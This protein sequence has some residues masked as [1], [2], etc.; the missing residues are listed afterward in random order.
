MKKNLLTLGALILSISASAQ[1]GNVLTYVGD[2]ALV[3]VMDGAL[4]Y[5]GGGW[6][7]SALG[8]VVNSGD[9]MVA[10][11]SA[12]MFKLDASQADAFVLK[13]TDS[14]TYGQLYISGIAQ[15]NIGGKVKKE[16]KADY[17]H[18]TD[19][20]SLGRQQ[21][22]L[23]FHGYTIGDLKRDLGG[24]VNV[25]NTNLNTSGRFNVASAF[26]WNNASKRYDQIS[27]ADATT[28]GSPLHYIILPRRS[29]NADAS[30]FQLEWDAANTVKDFIGIPAADNAQYSELRLTPDGNSVNFG[31]NGTNVNYYRERYNSYIVDPF[32][33]STPNW[34]TDYG[35]NL[36]QFANP[37]LTNLDLSRI[38]GD[39]GG[40]TDGINFS[41]IEGI[42]YFQGSAVKWNN[43]IG[44]TYESSHIKTLLYVGGALQAGDVNAA[45]IKP[46]GEFYI[47]MKDNVNTTIPIRNARRF[48]QTARTSATYSPASGKTTFASAIPADLVVKQVAVVLKDAEGEELGRTY[49]AVSQSSE[50][51][52]SESNRLQSYT[53]ALPIYTKEE[54]PTG[55]EDVN[56]TAKLY[57]N[58]ANEINFAKKKLPLFINKEQV[59]RISF[60]LYEGGVKLNEGESLS[61]GKSF[62]IKR[63]N[64][65]TR[66]EA[67]KS[68]AFVN[69]DFALYYDAPEG[70]LGTESASP[71][72][73]T[74]VAKKSSDWV[75][76]F[77]K[78]WKQADVEVYS[79]AGQLV[80]SAKKVSTSQDYVIP[81]S[82]EVKGMFIVKTTSSKGEVVTKKIVN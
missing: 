21:V 52:Y 38:A 79:A 43:E 81:L 66:I 62:Y 61:T 2:N 39:L 5:S 31:V 3:T 10:A 42:S 69:G 51:G 28:I 33:A 75:I 44:S 54:L 15:G 14:N 49:Y 55:G 60:E 35:K 46:M 11:T 50:T 82:T 67:D 22:S 17:N 20:N 57:I 78:D 64:E 76:R 18:S 32:R 77:A 16:Y 30:T 80:F 37:F 71:M 8:K 41:N 53:D 65:I 7:N 34:A 4:I 45:V 12:D 48:A 68:I 6:E 56:K 73:Q 63:D 23:P 26:K 13:Y 70:F 29:Q 40:D 47:K 59:A 9:V 27:G 19:V 72:S 24:F 1:T 58:T 25:T 36:F 74:I